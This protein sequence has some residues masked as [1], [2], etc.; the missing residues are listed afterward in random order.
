[1]SQVSG[2]LNAQVSKNNGKGKVNK[3]KMGSG[4]RVMGT[5]REGLMDGQNLGQGVSFLGHHILSNP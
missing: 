4:K 5:H 3:I 1:M 2:T